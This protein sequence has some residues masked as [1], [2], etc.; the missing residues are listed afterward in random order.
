MQSLVHRLIPRPNHPE[1][2]AILLTE[3]ETALVVGHRL[4]GP[5]AYVFAVRD[6]QILGGERVGREPVDDTEVLVSGAALI[7]SYEGAA[8][9]Y[10]ARREEPIGDEPAARELYHSWRL[11]FSAICPAVERAAATS[12]K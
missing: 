4:P 5:A 6:G 8:M 12:R 2:D 1:P 11:L 7:V 10:A 9:I 3:H